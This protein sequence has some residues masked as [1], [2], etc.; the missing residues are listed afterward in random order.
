MGNTMVD[1]CIECLG[2]TQLSYTKQ[3]ELN[4]TEMILG[5]CVNG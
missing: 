5:F 3:P 1:I 4:S 2:G